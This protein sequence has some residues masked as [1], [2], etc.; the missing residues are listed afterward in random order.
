MKG[1][2]FYKLILANSN[3][4]HND[5]FIILE[6]IAVL[7]VI[8]ILSVIALSSILTTATN[9]CGIGSEDEGNLY[10]GSINRAQQSYLIEN[11]G[12]FSNSIKKLEIGI[13][14]ET[15]IYSYSLQTTDNSAFHYG[16]V[17]KDYVK[18][19]SFEKEPINSFVGAVFK[20]PNPEK[21][22]ALEFTTVTILCIN[23]KPGASIPNK[24]VLNNGIPSCGLG[25]TEMK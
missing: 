18:T 13:P 23:D 17:K 12:K 5:G 19:D 4:D 1:E 10:T 24:P 8:G 2:F 14:K 6:I 21:S 3:R 9:S 7:I 25:T 20:I 16:I 15:E 11:G 22:E